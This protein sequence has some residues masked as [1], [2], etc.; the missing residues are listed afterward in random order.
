M[1]ERLQMANSKG[2]QM[3]VVVTWTDWDS[4]QY[5]KPV[6]GTRF[7]PGTSEFE[8]QGST[9]MSWRSLSYYRTEIEAYARAWPSLRTTRRSPSMLCRQEVRHVN[10]ACLHESRN[11]CSR[12][13]LHRRSG[14]MAGVC[15]LWYCHVYE[16]T[17]YEVL[18]RIL[19]LLT[20]YRA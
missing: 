18:D 3:T 13:G 1:V 2:T 16:V 15:T 19:Y 5:R 9:A 17:I 8:A 6:P 7:Q 4:S 20:T 10:E 12:S 14:K 11:V